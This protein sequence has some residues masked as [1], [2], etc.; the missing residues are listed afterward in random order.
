[1]GRGR[2]PIE[3]RNDNIDNGNDVALLSPD[4]HSQT[5]LIPSYHYGMY[6]ITSNDPVPESRP[7]RES[8]YLYTTRHATI[9]RVCIVWLHNP[10]KGVC[11][12][13]AYLLVNLGTGIN[14]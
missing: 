14:K 11:I 9:G 3:L 4:L 5:T 1:M 7:S 8:V 10:P 13:K 12:T 2:T 6:S